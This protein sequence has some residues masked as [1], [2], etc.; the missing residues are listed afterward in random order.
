MDMGKQL[1][2]WDIV[3]P[4]SYGYPVIQSKKPQK[5]SVGFEWEVQEGE[6]MDM[7]DEE[8][9][10]CMYQEY[11]CDKYTSQFID[12]YKFKAHGECMSTEFCSPVAY[13][14][15]TIKAIARKLAKRVAK[16]P[17]LEPNWSE[18]GGIHVHTSLGGDYT[19]NNQV[20]KKVIL[21]LNRESSSRFVWDFSGRENA[22]SCEYTHQAESSCWDED[23]DYIPQTYGRLME[24]LEEAQM[25]RTNGFGESATIEY[26]LFHGVAER[27]LPA[28]EF[29]HA[30]TKFVAQHKGDNI[31]YLVQFK[32]W[33]FKQR[34]YKLLKAQPEW[35][36]V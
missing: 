33:L 23:G 27:L 30:C 35:A 24:D 4:S 2:R 13:N 5:I 17:T 15:Q 21:M 32:D 14:L 20:F 12:T 16:D 6:P 19:L 8:Y 22:G 9:D 26:R 36:L 31:P 28:L 18:M 29:S 3:R 10:Q 25:V 11:Y 7:S 1:K 34:G